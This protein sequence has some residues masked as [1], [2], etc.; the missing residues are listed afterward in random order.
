[1]ERGAHPGLAH[2]IGGHRL[3]Y[4]A[5]VTCVAAPDPVSIEAVIFD[6][7]GVLML[8]NLAEGRRE[9]DLQIGS[10]HQS[11]DLR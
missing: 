5:S 10:D 9:A 11:A 4:L 1:M 3:G 8:P 2:Q 7:G 6:A